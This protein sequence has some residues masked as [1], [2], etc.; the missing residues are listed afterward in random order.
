MIRC[1]VDTNVPIVANGRD[2]RP[3]A[4]GMPTIKCRAAAVA[5]L[6]KVLHEGVVLL[7]I[8]GAIL[9]EYKK[10]LN[11]SGQPGVGDRFYLEILNS[12]PGIVQ[13]VD[14]PKR[15]DGEYIDLHQPVIDDGF[16]RGDWKFAA[17][18]KRE[19]APVINCVDSDW[20]IH[21]KVLTA[22]GIVVKFLCGGDNTKW[23]TN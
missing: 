17:L 6:Q 3:G 15:P 1:A 4:K 23:F 10:Y 13:R 16:D 11:P 22:T 5:F 14:L 19:N 20:L 7:D 18:A 21:A 9:R 2:E 12:K 8:E